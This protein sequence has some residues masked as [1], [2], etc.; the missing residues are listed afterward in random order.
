MYLSMFILGL[1]VFLQSAVSLV[2]F[3]VDPKLQGFV[4][5]AFVVVLVIEAFFAV[6]G[7]RN[8]IIEKRKV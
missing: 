4:G 5:I 8:V 7:R 3:T 6:K 2:W 1:Y